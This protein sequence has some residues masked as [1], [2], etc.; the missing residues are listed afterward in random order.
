MTLKV[1]REAYDDMVTSG[2]VTLSFIAERKDAPLY[3]IGPERD[4]T[5]FDILEQMTGIRPPLVGVE[6]ASYVV[7]TGLFNDLTEQPSDYDDRLSV[8]HRRKLDFIS[9][10]PDLVVH[11]GDKLIYCSGAIAERY[12]EAGGRV[13]QAGKPFRPI[14]E[15]AVALAGQ[16]RGGAPDLRR[17]LAIG[18]ALRTDIQGACDFGIDALF[19][20]SGIHRGDLHAAG[21]LDEAA[22]D[23]AL[24][25]AGVRPVAAIPELVW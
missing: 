22:L 6:E 15:R 4:H 21:A 24:A 2:D 1:P 8:M 13:L 18:D 19:V 10:N 7:C 9:A 5:L 25:E 3:H 23:R 12:E 17:V 11:V 20:T 14:Y 16:L